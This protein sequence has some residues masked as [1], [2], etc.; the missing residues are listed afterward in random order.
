MT[1][2]HA[3]FVGVDVGGTFTDV[4][5]ADSAGGVTIGKVLTTPD[6]PRRGVVEG[7]R[8]VLDRAGVDAGAVSRLVHGTT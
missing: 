6:D 8:H 4:V 7:I 2:P 1:E 3:H 5:L